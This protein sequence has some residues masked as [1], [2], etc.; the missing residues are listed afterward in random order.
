MYIR[1][2]ARSR[3]ACFASWKLD[4]R[5]YFFCSYQAKNGL[6]MRHR[7]RFGSIAAEEDMV[8]VVSPLQRKLL[9]WGAFKMRA[10]LHV[11]LHYF[12]ML[13]QPWK[14]VYSH[15]PGPCHLVPPIGL[16]SNMLLKRL[17]KP[18]ETG[19]D[20]DQAFLTILN[21][22][23]QECLDLQVCVSALTRK[24]CSICL[25]LYNTRASKNITHQ[26]F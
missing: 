13:L 16:H 15:T 3:T 21:K 26:H 23:R 1:F 20:D 18:G 14:V 10:Q 7:V 8:T 19:T 5:S 25:N 17:H 11:Q 24:I 2:L 9:H 6:E 4:L 12:S 22:A